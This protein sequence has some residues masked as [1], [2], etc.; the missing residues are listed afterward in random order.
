MGVV[1]WRSRVRF[2]DAGA[3]FRSGS[4]LGRAADAA[5]ARKV[6]DRRFALRWLTEARSSSL[7][8]VL[9]TLAPLRDGMAQVFAS[10]ASPSLVTLARTNVARASVRKPHTASSRLGAFALQRARLPRGPALSAASSF[11]ASGLQTARSFS[12]GGGG[13][14]LFENVI[15]NAPLALRAAGLELDDGLRKASAMRSQSSFACAQDLQRHSAVQKHAF[16]DVRSAMSR[17]PKLESQNFA[18]ATAP[19]DDLELLFP[20]SA[21]ESSNETDFYPRLVLRIPLEPEAC[22]QTRADAA[23]GSVDDVGLLLDESMRADLGAIRHAYQTHAARVAEL[24]EL[25]RSHG[26]WPKAGN[27]SRFLRTHGLR[28]YI[29]LPLYGWTKARIESLLHSS[30]IGTSV[31]AVATEEEFAQPSGSPTDE[32]D[33]GYG[34]LE[35]PDEASESEYSLVPSELGFSEYAFNNISSIHLADADRAGNDFQ[36]VGA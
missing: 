3:L 31:S 36:R 29:E 11:R 18:H 14:R 6:G 30:S 26:I 33:D 4:A 8:S 25:L 34:A 28:T 27:V 21:P 24:E 35:S 19:Q 12:S 5:G 20:A 13:A 15:Y 7:R 16:C 9:R 10:S 22:V 23:R 1:P 32:S 17:A 2:R